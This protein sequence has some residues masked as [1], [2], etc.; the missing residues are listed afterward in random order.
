MTSRLK[1]SL[2][3]LYLLY[4]LNTVSIKGLALDPEI[5]IVVSAITNP[6]IHSLRTYEKKIIIGIQYQPN[7]ILLT[8]VCIRDLDKLNLAMVLWF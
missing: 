1:S 4:L 8:T 5:P 7:Y 6:L 3:K 2:S